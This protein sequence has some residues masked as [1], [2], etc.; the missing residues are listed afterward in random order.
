M[1]GVEKPIVD[2]GFIKV[3]DTPGL[4]ISLNDDELKRHLSRG[5][6]FSSQPQCGMNPNR[7]MTRY[8]ADLPLLLHDCRILY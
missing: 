1:T 2:K 3:P 5:P 8:S 6:V 7:G 4:G